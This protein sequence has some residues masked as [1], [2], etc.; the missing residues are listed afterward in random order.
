[1]KLSMEELEKIAPKPLL[2]SLKHHA[3]HKLWNA[4]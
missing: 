2:F 3:I 1:M 4:A